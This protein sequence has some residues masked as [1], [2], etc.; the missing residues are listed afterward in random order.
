MIRLV[1]SFV[2]LFSLLACG[3]QPQVTVVERQQPKLYRPSFYTVVQGDTLFKIAWTYGLDLHDLAKINKLRKPYTLQIGQKILLADN[4]YHSEQSSSKSF[5]SSKTKTPTKAV[6][7]PKPVRKKKTVS[8]P[9]PAT[10][11]SQAKYYV[12]GMPAWHWPLQQPA[13]ILNKFGQGHNKGVDLQGNRGDAV[14]SAAAGVV[15][16]AGSGLKGYGNLIIIKHNAEYLSAY[17]HNERLLVKEGAKIRRGQKIASLGSSGTDQTKLHF[18]IRRHGK[19][20]NP[21]KLLPARR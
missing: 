8:K 10:K 16:F 12:K 7:K 15:V 19:P 18:E 21:L 14:L 3:S 13:R 4:S 6:A 2:L 1:I 5:L 20:V 17:A 9:R 11:A